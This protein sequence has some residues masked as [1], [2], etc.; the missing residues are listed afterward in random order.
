LRKERAKEE[1]AVVAVV[2]V[3][4]GHLPAEAWIEE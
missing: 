3:L 4:V 1:A 2:A